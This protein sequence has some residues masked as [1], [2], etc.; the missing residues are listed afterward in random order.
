MTKTDLLLLKVEIEESINTFNK[1]CDILGCP[2][3]KIII[4][5]NASTDNNNTGEIP[6]EKF[7]KLCDKFNELPSTSR[8]PDDVRRMLR[9]MGIPDSVVKRFSAGEDLQDFIIPNC[10]GIATVE[11]GIGYTYKIHIL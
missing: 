11:R 5:E 7:I 6:P 4:G 2:N 8:D 9:T 10:D 3:E 1:K